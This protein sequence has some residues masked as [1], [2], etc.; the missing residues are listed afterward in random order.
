MLISIIPNSNKKSLTV[1]IAGGLTNAKNALKYFSSNAD[2]Q[3]FIRIWKKFYA[4]VNPSLFFSGFLSLKSKS[5]AKQRGKATGLAKININRLR[6]SISCSKCRN[7]L[8]K[9]L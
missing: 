7:A 1:S 8:I 2:T 3:E 9:L 6:G 5:I 4:C